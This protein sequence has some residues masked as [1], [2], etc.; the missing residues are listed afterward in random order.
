MRGQSGH[1]AIGT[2]PYRGH[3]GW[4]VEVELDIP[5]RPAL[6]RFLAGELEEW[7]G[8]GDGRCSVCWGKADG[9]LAYRPTC[10]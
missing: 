2:G 3:D 9:G 5:R 4:E 10:H 1:H 8:G 7:V 6:L